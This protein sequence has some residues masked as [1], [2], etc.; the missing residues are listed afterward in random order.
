MEALSLD[1]WLPGLRLLGKCWHWW[2]TDYRWKYEFVK[3]I[4]SSV[5]EE[6]L[7]AEAPQYRTILEL[8]RKVRE[9]KLPPHLNVIMSPE[10]EHF[11][12]L[13]YMRSCIL[14]QYRAISE[15]DSSGS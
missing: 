2:N 13:V 4:L 12:P 8:D 1:V 6:S 7:T 5:L 9:K 10:E 15:C 3:E 14:G 11:T